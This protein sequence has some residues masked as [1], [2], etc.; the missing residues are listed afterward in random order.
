MHKICPEINLTSSEPP[1]QQQQPT[2]PRSLR[3]RL[4]PKARKLIKQT[5]LIIHGSNS[6]S[7][8]SNG[9]VKSIVEADVPDSLNKVSHLLPFTYLSLLSIS[10]SIL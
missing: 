3:L 7:N 4:S 5:S 6:S 8:N 9:N 2:V 1:Q 10:L